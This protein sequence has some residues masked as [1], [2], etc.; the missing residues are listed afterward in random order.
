[1][2]LTEIRDKT[3]DYYGVDMSLKSRAKLFSNARKMYCYMARLNKHKL[4]IIGDLINRPHDV[5]IYHNKIAKSWVKSRDTQFLKD[6]NEVFNIEAGGTSKE[7]RLKKLHYRY[8]KVLLNIPNELH[9][10]IIE[11]IELRVKASKWKQKDTLK[12]YVAKDSEMIGVY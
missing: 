5:V 2:E 10:D 6:I 11:M 4:Q 1:M 12:L 3:E 8:D 7:R 9:N